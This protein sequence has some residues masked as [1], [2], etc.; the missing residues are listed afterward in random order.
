LKKLLA[1][2][3]YKDIRKRLRDKEWF[4]KDWLPPQ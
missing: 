2:R 4:P 3:D 1:S